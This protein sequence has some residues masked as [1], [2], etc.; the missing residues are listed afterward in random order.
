ME[1]HQRAEDSAGE[2]TAE[3]KREQLVASSAERRRQETSYDRELLASLAV[4]RLMKCRKLPHETFMQFA[5]ALRH[6]GDHYAIQESLYVAAFI[7]GIGSADTAHLVC[8]SKPV[9]LH[10]AAKTAILIERCDGALRSSLDQRKRPQ[11]STRAERPPK[12]PRREVECYQCHKL[13]HFA[14]DCPQR[15]RK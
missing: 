14:R 11:V 12:R 15:A 4:A 7:E 9:D 8:E 6:A 5:A 10:D 2:T 1:S 13:G 3:T